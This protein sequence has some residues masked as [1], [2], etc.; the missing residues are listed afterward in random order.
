[1]P[2]HLFI[3]HTFQRCFKFGLIPPKGQLLGLLK[4]KFYSWPSSDHPVSSIEALNELTLLVTI[5][6]V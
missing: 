3:T 2:Q 5:Q 4:W 6:L 1:M